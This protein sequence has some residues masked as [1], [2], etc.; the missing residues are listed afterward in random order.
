MGP[1]QGREKEPRKAVVKVKEHPEILPRS[2]RASVTFGIMI[3]LAPRLA[4]G[5]SWEQTWTKDTESF[6]SQ[7]PPPSTTH[8]SLMHK[9]DLRR[10]SRKPPG[11]KLAC[12]QAEFLRSC[13]GQWWGS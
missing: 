1:I 9:H 2:A 8:V 13:P 6:L 5:F 4:Q 12:E 7:S 11:R 3:V 10:E